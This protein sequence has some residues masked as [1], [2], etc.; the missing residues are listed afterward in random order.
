MQNCTGRRWIKTR[1]PDLY[2]EIA[3]ATG[4]E[5][6]TRKVRFDKKGV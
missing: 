5:E 4:K 3:V 1:R 2:K 6:D